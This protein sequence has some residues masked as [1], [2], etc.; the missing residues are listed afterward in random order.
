MALPYYVPDPTTPAT[1]R[2]T[3][4]LG[5]GRMQ[6]L[7]SNISLL[8][9]RNARRVVANHPGIS[10]WNATPAGSFTP[11]LQPYSVQWDLDVKAGGCAICLGDI[12]IPSNYPGTPVLPAIILT[13]RARVRTGGAT[14]GLVL[15]VT[16]GDDVVTGS[17]VAATGQT[18]TN[19]TFQS[20]GFGFGTSGSPGFELPAPQPETFSPAPFGSSPITDHGTAYRC[21]LWFGGW[22][23]TG[24]ADAL[25]L[26]VYLAP[27][28]E[29]P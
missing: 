21:T 16:Q 1:F 19:T 3:A 20:F 10:N 7:A 13:V 29:V 9:Q 4:P 24:H 11:A 12:L 6:L 25:G 18:V 14:A 17:V 8:Q 2:A 22:V 27:P 23:T 15:V 26:S 5:A 28:N